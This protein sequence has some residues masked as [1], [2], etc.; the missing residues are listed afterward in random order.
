MLVYIDWSVNPIALEV[1]PVTYH[2]YGILFMSALVFTYW[3]IQHLFKLESIN[4]KNLFNSAL[5]IIF[6]AVAGARLGEV[7]FY[8]WDYFKDHLSEIPMIWQGGLASH[9]GGIGV[10]LG[11][12][13]ASKF[14]LKAPTL[15]IL[16]RLAVVSSAGLGLIRIG[17]LMNHEIIGDPT[18]VPWAFIFHN[19]SVDLQPRHP[20]QLYEAIFFGLILI[21]MWLVYKRTHVKHQLGYLTGLFFILM[22]GMRFGVEFIKNSQGGL[23]ENLG[24]ILSTGQLLSIPFILLG[25][26]LMVLSKKWEYKEPEK[27]SIAE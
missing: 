8:S 19:S 12:W 20:A 27:I 2:W 14:M 15:W 24:N 3:W 26:A 7:F 4:E 11:A 16:D 1:G 23:E 6:G 13:I 22:P 10:L 25:I 5:V 21:T 18:D 17:N 9:G